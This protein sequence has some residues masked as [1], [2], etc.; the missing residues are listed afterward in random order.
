MASRRPIRRTDRT[1][2]WTWTRT[3]TRTRC[4]RHEHSRRAHPV[5][6][7]HGVRGFRRGRLRR[8]ILGPRRRWSEARGTTTRGHR[9]LN[10][11][12]VGS[13]PRLAD[14]QLRAPLDF[15]TYAATFSQARRRMLISCG[16]TGSGSAWRYCVAMMTRRS[17]ASMS[18]TDGWVLVRYHGAS[19][20][21]ASTSVGWWPVVAY[22]QTVRLLMT[23]A[24]GVVRSTAAWS[25]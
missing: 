25:R 16:V 1:S 2:L 23:S 6:R 7:R 8:R 11:S 9:S 5:H 4:P 19:S 24:N 17:L 3:R 10:R 12:G 15:R 21:A 14:L 18:R 13:E 20:R 22:Q